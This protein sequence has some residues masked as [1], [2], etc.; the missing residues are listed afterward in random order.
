MEAQ[1]PLR[2]WVGGVSDPA[3]QAAAEI[4][5]K[6]MGYREFDVEATAEII[7]RALLSAQRSYVEWIN[8]VG[9]IETLAECV[10]HGDNCLAVVGPNISVSPECTCGLSKLRDELRKQVGGE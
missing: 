6:V 2:Q 3:K 1:E 10:G 8:N 9:G 5:D 7:Q 4:A